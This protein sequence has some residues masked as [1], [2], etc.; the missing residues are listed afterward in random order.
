MDQP[1]ATQEESTNQSPKSGRK[2]LIIGAL[3]LVVALIGGGYA[4]WAS[5]SAK[6]EHEVVVIAPMAY[7]AIDPPFV[8]NLAGSDSQHLLQVSVSVATR[9]PHTLE[10]MRSNLPM[11]RDAMLMRFAAQDVLAVSTAVAKERLRVQVFEDVR[12]V[13]KTAGGDPVNV[14]AVYFD[15]FVVQ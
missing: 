7:F 2:G 4:W 11:L 3:V 12:R 8:T 5:R 1:A 9:D 6:P 10:V 14:Y 13:V 15:G